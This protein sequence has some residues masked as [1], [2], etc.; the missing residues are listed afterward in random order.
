MAAKPI[1]FITIE[2]KIV[3]ETHLRERCSRLVP[4]LLANRGW[5]LITDMPAFIAEVCD[6]ARRRLDKM[7]KNLSVEKVIEL[8]A[9]NR[10][11]QH[12]YAA[13]QSTE[14]LRQRLAFTELHRYLYNIAR[15][16]QADTYV[17]EEAVQEALI[18]TWQSLA[19]VHD[20]GAF[21]GYAKMVLLR[22]LGHRAAAAQKQ[23]EREPAASDLQ[24]GKTDKTPLNALP[25][26]NEEQTIPPP[27][28]TPSPQWE[29]ERL[30]HLKAVIRRCL[31][32]SVERQAVIIGRYLQE[33]TVKELADE[34]QVTAQQIYLLSSRALA[35]LRRCPELMQLLLL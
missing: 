16:K 23:H 19:R 1:T 32:R 31:R 5:Q 6:E 2:G 21:M 26:S 3:E 15:Y 25:Q 18:K 7:K 20:P 22:E 8:A 17:A 11:N 4:L 12:W 29:K 24:L 28:A 13:C 14:P 30:A 10:Y 27:N 9:I 35:A 33:K 34:L